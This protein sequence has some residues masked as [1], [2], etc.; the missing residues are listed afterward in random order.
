MISDDIDYR[1]AV[2]ADALCL[3][4]LAMQVYLDTYAIQGIRP[5]IARDALE[6]GSVDAF[7][8]LLAGTA[9]TVVV[10]E[11]AGHLVGFAQVTHGATHA[12]LAP[13]PA[14]ELLRLYVQEPFTA[15]GI[16]RELLRRAERVAAA[17]GAA[18]LWLTAWVGNARA[19]AFYPRQHYADVGDTVYTFEGERF[20]NKLFARDLRETAHARAATR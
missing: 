4:V 11:R 2:A 8:A 10:A 16:G 1:E 17:R 20:P 6:H 9:A 13:G 19:L 18:T 7:A 12:L 5:A 3:G 14:A 15:R